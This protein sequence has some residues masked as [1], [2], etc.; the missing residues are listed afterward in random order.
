LK[1]AA[2]VAPLFNPSKPVTKVDAGLKPTAN[3]GA[4]S[5]DT[6][7]QADNKMLSASKPVVILGTN[8]I[9]VPQNGLP[10]P[11][12]ATD[13]TPPDAPKVVYSDNIFAKKPSAVL[14][15]EKINANTNASAFAKKPVQSVHT[16]ANNPGRAGTSSSRKPMK[17]LQ[18]ITN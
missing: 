10:Q 14:R 11:A 18:L 15:P 5:R 13:E 16:P 9:A 8:P 2:Q 12:P 1:N 6:L 17:E 3:P 4:V 7:A